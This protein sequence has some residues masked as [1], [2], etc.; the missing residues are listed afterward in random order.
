MRGQTFCPVIEEEQTASGLFDYYVL[1]GMKFWLQTNE[2]RT[3]QFASILAG[4]YA[5]I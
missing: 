2:A 4:Y 3:S 1:L 5:L